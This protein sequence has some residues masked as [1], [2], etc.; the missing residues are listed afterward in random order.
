MKSKSTDWVIQPDTIRRKALRRYKEFLQAWFHGNVSELFPIEIHGRKKVASQANWSELVRQMQLLREESKEHRKRGYRVDWKSINSPRFGKNDFPERIF[1]DTCEDY[2]F[3]I[4]KKQEFLVLE[5]V[6]VQIRDLFPELERCLATQ[7]SILPHLADDI[8]PLIALLKFFREHPKPDCFVREIPAPGVH[9]KF[10]ERPE[11]ENVLR[12]WLDVILPA[13]AIRSDEHHFARRYFLRY[14]EQLIRL[15]FLDA[16]VQKK[17]HFPCSDVSVPLHTF[18]NLG[19]QD[20]NV[21]IVENKTSLL[22]LP[23]SPNTIALGGLG[24]AVTLLKY[25]PWLRKCRLTYWGD[26]DSDGFRILSN[27]REI[28]PAVQSMLMDA[29]TLQRFESLLTKGN[30]QWHEIPPFLTEDEKSAFL[31]CRNENIRLEQ[32]RIPVSALSPL[33]NFTSFG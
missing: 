29:A 22:T 5:S 6:V 30:G 25:A 21:I 13:W 23:T 17:L 2:L 24:Y 3:L 32:E 14:D 8:E 20:I 16:A 11:I 4:E 15:R 12:Q 18:A 27:F 28:F 10:I 31:R 26:L 9:T 33:A 19:I 7:L 1:I